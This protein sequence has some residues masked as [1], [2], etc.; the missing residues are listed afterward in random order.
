LKGALWRPH[1]RHLPAITEPKRFGE[2]L[3]AIDN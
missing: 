2:L 3:R 1:A